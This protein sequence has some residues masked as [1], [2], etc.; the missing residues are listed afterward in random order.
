MLLTLGTD[1]TDGESIY[2]GGWISTKERFVHP[3]KL[4]QE[5]EKVDSFLDSFNSSEFLL[6]NNVFTLG[7]TGLNFADIILIYVF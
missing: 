1:G 7:P 2:A 4:Q 5:L 6:P 3:D